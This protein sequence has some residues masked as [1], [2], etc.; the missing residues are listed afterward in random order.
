MALWL[1]CHNPDGTRNDDPWLTNCNG[2]PLGV[3]A[4]NG[5]QGTGE[6]NH[7]GGYAVDLGV[8]I[9]GVY[10]GTLGYYHTIAGVLVPLAATLGV[11][12]VYGGAWAPP[13]TDSDHFELDR[14]FY[15]ATTA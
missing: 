4:P 15:P 12:M 8:L 9:G 6:S 7:Q 1:K 11:H 13:K 3:L 10:Q 14:K 2:Y 5:I